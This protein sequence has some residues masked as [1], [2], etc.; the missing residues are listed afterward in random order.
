MNEN[1]YR[2]IVLA[3][4]EEVYA[5][6]NMRYDTPEAAAE[7]AAELAS[8]WFAVRAYTVIS[9]ELAPD[10]GSYWS[11]ELVTAEALF[12]IRQC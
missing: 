5:S 8:R 3:S 1:K 2:I 4:G 10:R 12:P 7:A 11:P 9:A 6:N